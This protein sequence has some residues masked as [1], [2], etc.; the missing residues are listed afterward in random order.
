MSVSG[1]LLLLTAGL[2]IAVALTLFLPL[3]PARERLG[4]TA[5]RQPTGSIDRSDDRYW[6]ACLFYYNP[7]DPDPFVPKRF[8]IGWTINFGHPG[9]KL[10][11]AA[12]L[13]LLLLP[14]ALAIFAPGLGH[15]GYGC[16][17]SGCR[18]TP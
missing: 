9:G 16:H 13:A 15:A 12:I 17:P 8:G 2:L 5:E 11:G 10:I 1:L 7:D 14:V 3:L 18:F 4:A 6:F